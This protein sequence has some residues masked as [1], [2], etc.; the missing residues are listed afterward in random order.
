[1]GVAG[2]VQVRIKSPRGGVEGSEAGGGG[3]VSSWTMPIFGVVSRPPSRHRAGF[4]DL[5]PMQ[6][7]IADALGIR[8]R[9][10]V[11]FELVDVGETIRLPIWINDTIQSDVE[12]I[13]WFKLGIAREYNMSS[14]S[15][16]VVLSSGKTLS[17]PYQEMWAEIKFMCFRGTVGLHFDGANSSNPEGPSGYA[18]RIT[19]EE[20]DGITFKSDFV[21]SLVEKYFPEP[22]LI[23]G[24]GYGGMNR[25]ESEMQYTGL[26]EG[27]IWALRLD[28]KKVK[29]YGTPE[30]LFPEKDKKAKKLYKKIRALL[31]GK[32]NKMTIV[33]SRVTRKDEARRDYRIVQDLVNRGIDSRENVTV[34]NWDN[35]NKF[36]W[37]E[38]NNFGEPNPYQLGLFG[39]LKLLVYNIIYFIFA[40]ITRK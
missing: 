12:I 15:T 8:N 38:Y 16:S 22:E 5:V 1:M 14:T 23:R 11:E 19:V 27:L 24:Y 39:Q 20:D 10:V 25:T 2:N 29:I 13:D 4:D 37:L 36:M 33:Y 3:I 31:Y 30:H 40:W 26:V 35:V 7:R 9:D 28:A 18:F 32:H 6:S 21:R 17:I 34:C